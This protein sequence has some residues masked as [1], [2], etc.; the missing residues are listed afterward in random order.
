MSTEKE[1]DQLFSRDEIIS[2][3]DTGFLPIL[4]VIA[5]RV[6]N[7]RTT[8]EEIKFFNVTMTL[9]FDDDGKE[10]KYESIED[11]VNLKLWPVTQSDID[12]VVKPEESVADESLPEGS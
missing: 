3:F 1:E 5:K 10:L 8:E 7:L 12:R 4:E 9:Q 11:R 2:M 6:K